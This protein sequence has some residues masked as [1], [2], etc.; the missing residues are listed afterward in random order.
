MTISTTH[1]PYRSVFI[2]CEQGL[3]VRLFL[4]NVDISLLFRRPYSTNSFF[5]SFQFDSYSLFSSGNYRYTAAFS[6][7][8]YLFF[9]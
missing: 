5:P 9:H 3:F 8:S 2:S 1:I 4:I 6:T 7:I